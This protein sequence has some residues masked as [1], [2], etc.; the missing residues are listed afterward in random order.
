[1]VELSTEAAVA[2]AAGGAVLV[3]LLVALLAASVRRNRATARR[4]GAVAARL[5]VPGAPPSDERD[6]VN[7]LER[8]AEAAVL[9]LS[10]ADAKAERLASALKELP[11]GI[12]VCDEHGSLVYRNDAATYLES[13]E[14]G[15]GVVGESLRD[16]LLA[17]VA[18]E[19]RSGIVDLVGPPRRTLTITGRPVD[20]GRRVVGAVAVLDDTS[21]QRRLE[22]LRRD[23]VTNATAELKAPVG[24]LGLLAGTIVA[25][26]DAA[27]TRRLA[28]RL[29]QDALRVGRLID[30]LAELSRLEAQALPTRE[31]VSV[32]LV[33]AQAVE[34]AR[35]LAVHR[36]I[37]IEAREA[38]G[39]LSVHGDRRQ[40]VSA[41]RHL[42]EN[43]VKFSEEGTGV[44]IKVSAEGGWVDVSVIDRGVGVPARDLERIFETFYRADHT[45]ARDA[46]GTGLGLA[47]ASRVAS[48]HG[49][50]IQV[51]SKEGKGS[52][53]TLRLPLAPGALA[54]GTQRQV[55]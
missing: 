52:T 47:I 37:A 41:L 11:Q 17:A 3:V 15:E 51:S 29:E 21:E 43:A 48:G 46:S 45:R 39:G 31:P 54:A 36:A 28:M 8:L 49:G 22:A 34:E 50:E 42:V 24:A 44:R 25:E 2:A 55:S 1:M 27:L 18:G 35:S 40:L 30:D 26:D 20:D 19:E 38:P 4:L 16:V 32:H 12:V 6:D 13:A 5:E 53:F 33:V 10:D 7:R 23:F 14:G 9:R